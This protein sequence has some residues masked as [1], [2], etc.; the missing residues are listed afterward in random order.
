[1][2]HRQFVDFTGSTWDVWEVRPQA[3]EDAIRKVRA[4]RAQGASE[5]S[6]ASPVNRALAEGWLC[7]ENGPEKRRLAPI[8]EGWA[9]ESDATLETLCAQATAVRR[10]APAE[11]PGAEIRPR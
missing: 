10:R 11:Q 1:M 4:E 3:A 5:W 2:P 8:P 7:F 6:G 9:Q